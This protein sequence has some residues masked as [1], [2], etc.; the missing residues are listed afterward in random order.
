MR[1]TFIV[2]AAFASLVATQLHAS[3]AAFQGTV[4]LVK[5]VPPNQKDAIIQFTCSIDYFDYISWG[6]FNSESKT[7]ELITR[8]TKKIGTAAMIDGRLVNVSTFSKAIKPGQ[9]GYFYEDTWLDLRTTPNFEWGEVVAHDPR[10]KIFT[11]K[12]H[13][14]HKQ[15]HLATNPPQNVDLSYDAHTRFCDENRTSTADRALASGNWVQIHP[16]RKQIINAW[17]PSSAFDPNELLPADQGKRGY[18]NDLTAPAVLLAVE[19]K[20]PRAVIDLSCNVRVTQNE[21]DKSIK[22]DINCRKTSFIL[23]GKLCPAAV[24]VREGRHAVL[25][26]YRSET[27]PHKIFVR[28]HDNSFRGVIKSVDERGILIDLDGEDL[29]VEIAADAVIRLDGA[30]S[31]ATALQNGNEITVFPRRGK[32]IVNFGQ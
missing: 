8:R 7:G 29:M 22:R 2:V 5:R 16:A 13:R 30:L 4:T 14:T 9:W 3:T 21:N 23:D 28:S 11:L 20:T 19:T 24:A 18:A 27:S 31:P 17:S 15:I 1:I 6:K 12:V 26:H 10:K 32:T 25:G